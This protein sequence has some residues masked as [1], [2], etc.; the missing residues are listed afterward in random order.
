V[1]AAKVDAM[2]DLDAIREREAAPRHPRIKGRPCPTCGA[3]PGHP[4]RG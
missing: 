1:L 2:S 3:K 4:C